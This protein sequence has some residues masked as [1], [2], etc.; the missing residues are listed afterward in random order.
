MK[1]SILQQDYYFFCICMNACASMCACLFTCVWVCIRECIF[2]NMCMC[3]GGYVH[4][5]YKLTLDIAPQN[6]STLTF[7]DRV[8]KSIWSI[9]IRVR[10]LSREPQWSIAL[11]GLGSH[12]Y[13][14]RLSTFPVGVWVWTQIFMS[15]MANTKQ[16]EPSLHPLKYWLYRYSE[17]WASDIHA[18]SYH[19]LSY[20]GEVCHNKELLTH[21]RQ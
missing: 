1:S 15:F 7:Q 19:T 16:T 17:C 3:V 10:K 9:L 18:H 6:L 12:S 8:P 4:I 13:S 20:V 11:P 5:G 21:H 14:A 2:V